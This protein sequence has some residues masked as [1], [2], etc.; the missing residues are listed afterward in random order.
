[1]SFQDDQKYC[2]S[3][4]ICCVQEPFKWYFTFLLALYHSDVVERM[5]C[6]VKDVLKVFAGEN[7][8]KN[9][10][11]QTMLEEGQSAL[12]MTLKKVVA[13]YQVQSTFVKTTL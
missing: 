11:M 7:M 9:R 8:L 3:S 12:L 2:V 6:T 4:E 5:V 10:G 1:M 13:D